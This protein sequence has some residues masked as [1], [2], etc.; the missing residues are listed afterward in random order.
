MAFTYDGYTLP[1]SRARADPFNAPEVAHI[2]TPYGSRP[3]GIVSPCYAGPHIIQLG[4]VIEHASNWLTTRDELAA[5]LSRPRRVLTAHPSD[6]RWAIATPLR[7][8]FQYI[9]PTLGAWSCEF[10]LEDYL[11]AEVAT[12]YQVSASNANIGGTVYRTT[13]QPTVAGSASTPVLWQITNPTGSPTPASWT[14]TNASAEPAESIYTSGAI[15]ALTTLTIDGPRGMVYS[16]AL[17]NVI[18]YFPLELEGDIDYS[19]KG[20]HLTLNNTPTQG[21]AG[22]TGAAMAFNGTNESATQTNAAFGITGNLTICG[23]ARPAAALGSPSQGLFGR[24]ASN[25]GYVINTT[26]TGYRFTIGTGAAATSIV[27]NYADTPQSTAAGVWLFLCGVF[28]TTAGM[29]LYLGDQSRSPMV[30]AINTGATAAPTSGANPFSIGAA[31]D[32]AGSLQYFNGRAD[33]VAVFDTA[34]TA[35][36]VEDVW[37]YGVLAFSRT[38]LMRRGMFPRLYPR[39]SGLTQTTNTVQIDMDAASAPGTLRILGRYAARYE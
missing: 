39:A 12:A 37:R 21:V 25:A 28:S 17:T 7:P 33:E 9:G 4:G 11:Q 19:G 2:I 35:A 38:N 30:M 14:L 26:N 31:H 13:L 1:V 10:V 3:G 32:D 6:N 5:V 34:L 23:W 29:R 20:R 18:G 36:Q 8:R 22:V 16:T 24:M 15:A 27:A